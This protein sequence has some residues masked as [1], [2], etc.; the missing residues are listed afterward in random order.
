MTSVAMRTGTP[1]LCN[2]GFVPFGLQD[3]EQSL[4]ARFEA[5]VDRSPN[6]LAVKSRCHEFTY[7]SLDR[8][9]NRVAW[10]LLVHSNTLGERVALVLEQGA[11]LIAAI[12]GTLKS[13]KIYVPLDPAHPL[14]RLR[15]ILEDAAVACLVTDSANWPL[16]CDL[17]G[18][19]VH[20]LNVELLE[21]TVAENRPGIPIMPDHLA[22]ILY[23]SGSTG[24]PKGV[25][26]N[27]RNLLFAARTHT[28]ACLIGPNDRLS[29][30]AS[31][32]YAAAALNL[33]GSLLN[34]ATLLPFEVKTEGVSKLADWLES[35]H[36]TLYHSVPTLFRNLARS[37][38]GGERF[39]SLRVVCL[40]GEATL[41][42][43]VELYQRRFASDCVILNGLAA[44][45]TMVFRRYVVDK[46]TRL[47]TPVVPGGYA[48][49]GLDVVLVDD[50]G[51]P[52]P[53]GAVGEIAVQ[54]RYVALGYWRQPELTRQK[55]SQDELRTEVRRYRTGDLGRLTPDGCL[56][57]H[58]RKDFQIKVR[59]HRV[60]ASEIELALMEQPGVREAV[61][62]GR[63]RPD[64]DTELVA[65]VA[66]DRQ[67]APH[68]TQLRRALANRLAQ[69]LIPTTFVLL[70]ELPR[71]P[72]GKVDRLILPEWTAERA[73]RD[74]AYVAPRNAVEQQLARLWEKLLDVRP[75]GV[76][77]NFFE[78]GGHSLLAVQVVAEMQR[79]Y[80]TRL[81]SSCLFPDATIEHL[82]RLINARDRRVDERPSSLVEVQPRGSRPP[83]FCVHPLGGE[84]L[85]FA[86]LAHH[87]G[88]DQP[89]YAFQDRPEIATAPSI[90]DTA[91]HY[92]DALRKVQ[93]CGPY[94]LGGYS[95]GGTVAF[96]MAQQL[97]RS[98]E[99]I[100]LLA[101]LDHAP[102][103]SG[104]SRVVWHPELARHLAVQLI[105]RTVLFAKLEPAQRAFH[106]EKAL[107]S[108]W[109]R[110][111]RLVAVLPGLGTRR[112]TQRYDL[113]R[114][115]EDQYQALAL[116]PPEDQ[117]SLRRLISAEYQALV[118]YVPQPY[119]GRITL[120]RARAQPLFCSHD[121]NMRWGDL[122][123]GG[124]EV[125]EVPG[126]HAYILKEPFVRVL[127]A[128]LGSCLAAA[129][130]QWAA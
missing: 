74:H 35:E 64:G 37:L 73:P 109:R 87:L 128:A 19:G 6:Q 12:L 77:D 70:D 120:F 1:A 4:P 97:Q 56:E 92:I 127:A 51:S 88:P 108:T 55:F 90:A 50:N 11:P 30:L 68:A 71:T 23:T 61:V 22:S 124:L 125:H 86:R 118:E 18:A 76:T 42:E 2:P 89:F 96:E 58:G 59:G 29:L 32:S 26:Q 115:I 45:E 24:T 20:V 14:P 57:Y 105:E 81:P 129:Q 94:L 83:F 99:A 66:V 121:P 104:Y 31:C 63:Q 52:V 62:T 25:I 72:S 111:G 112:P 95:F 53:D 49:E 117:A 47:T 39:P 75:I 85:C 130:R 38:K 122:A 48:V 69:P 9:A 67:L 40:G 7:S 28:N 46:T 79:H 44:T 65:Y 15:Q 93:P 110:L 101:I 34:G 123:Q 78:L 17:A 36:I 113:G 100:A 10:A 103:T 114:F 3:T 21:G 60:E 41:K 102:F 13:G 33:Y 119:S 54:G 27:H 98:G 91:A 107:R 126:L 82:A 84:V 16:A 5:V 43:D 116:F 106:I 8:A 80:G